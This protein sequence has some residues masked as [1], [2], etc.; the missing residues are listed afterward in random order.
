MKRILVASDLSPTSSN[1][2]ARAINLAAAHHAAIRIVHVA[3]QETPR[4][5]R[6]IR[7]EALIMA[8]EMIGRE[9]DLSVCVSGGPEGQAIIRHADRFE[10]DLIVLGGHGAPRLRDALFGTTGTHI[11]RHSECPV[12][13]VQQDAFHPYGKVLLAIDN[14]QSAPPLLA[15]V[16]DIAPVAELFAVHAFYP[17]LRQAFGGSA[18]LSRQKARRQL[19]LEKLIGA[20][21]PSDATLSARGHVIV[22]TGEAFE[23]IMK[24]TEMLKPDILVLGTRR[25]ATFLG[26][27]A[28]DTLFWCPHDILVVPEVEAAITEASQP[29]AARPV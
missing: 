9:L 20:V 19:E 18:E 5:Y 24:E 14:V 8:E 21:R 22:E 10:A 13:V 1:A 17:S 29:W 27:H 12:L 11:V 15:T 4:M 3:D 23:V 16:G 26:S 6:R 7:A 2:L 28:V 25:E